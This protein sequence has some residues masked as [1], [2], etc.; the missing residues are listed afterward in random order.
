MDETGQK[1]DR[2]IEFVDSKGTERLRGLMM[3][4]RANKAQKEKAGQT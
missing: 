2:V 3:R 4:A 1:V